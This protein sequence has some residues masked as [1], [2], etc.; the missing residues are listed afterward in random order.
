MI[1]EIQAEDYL[2]VF[3]QHFCPNPIFAFPILTV[4]FPNTVE[5]TE[6]SLLALLHIAQHESCFLSH[7]KTECKFLRPCSKP[8]SARAECQEMVM[9]DYAV[10]KSSSM[11]NLSDQSLRD[12]L[13]RNQSYGLIGTIDRKAIDPKDFTAGLI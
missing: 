8:I 7:Q 10:Q 11:I 3:A 9:R 12:Q 2:I 1:L 6:Y 4:Q 5:S 13:L